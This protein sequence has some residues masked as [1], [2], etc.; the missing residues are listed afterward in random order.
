[1]RWVQY[2]QY[3]CGVDSALPDLDYDTADIPW[4]WLRE[5]CWEKLSRYYDNFTETDPAPWGADRAI[6]DEG[7][8]GYRRY[9]LLYGERIVFLFLEEA[10]TA[11]Q[12]AAITGA[13]RP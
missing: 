11:K 7:S 13:L 5:L 9:L 2:E 12:M 6:I 4:A 1:M 8:T 10:P 3:P